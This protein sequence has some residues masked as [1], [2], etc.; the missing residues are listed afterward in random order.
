VILR[1]AVETNESGH[2]IRFADHPV[3]FPFFALA[4]FIGVGTQ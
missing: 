3:F 4:H 1:E 2:V